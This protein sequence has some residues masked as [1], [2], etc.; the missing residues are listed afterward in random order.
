MINLKDLIKD[1]E[2]YK[3][4]YSNRNYKLDSEIDLVC[5]K[6]SDYLKIINESQGLSAELNQVSRGKSNFNQAEIKYARDISIKI[7]SANTTSKKLWEEIISISSHF[8]NLYSENVKV[9]ISELDNEIV[10]KKDYPN[11]KEEG[12]NHWEVMD[13][14][15]I[16]N[17]NVAT[18][19][20]GTRF[21]IYKK[22]GAKLIK[23]LENYFIDF[24]SSNNYEYIELPVIMNEKSLFNS[25]HLPKFEKEL[26]K[27]SNDQYLIPTSEAYLVNL[28]NKSIFKKEEL[29]IKLSS[30]T[31]CFRKE[32]GAAGNDTRGIIR[33]HQFRKVE[34]FRAGLPENKE[35]D[36]CE[37]VNEVKKLVESLNLSYRVVRLCSGDLS[38]SS[39][40]TYDI[41]VWMPGSKKYREVSSI[42]TTGSFQSRR[43]NA[44]FIDSENKK[45][46]LYL[47]NGS[48]IAVERIFAAIMENFYDGKKVLLPPIIEKYFG[49]SSF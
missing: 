14:K 45:D 16:W 38:F 43:V 26:Y 11:K 2:K 21:S 9:G 22:E 4:S 39:M 42:S 7:K 41:E 17:P 23:A 49:N 3:K 47:Y 28:F 10:F 31:N 33:T 34:I 1:K 15:E 24:N 18:N 25:G 8:P 5:K 30:L 29:P 46:F 48:S 37:M 19:L 40:E 36:L 12:L 44:K 32:A 20:S 27:I 6:Y 13:I 35:K